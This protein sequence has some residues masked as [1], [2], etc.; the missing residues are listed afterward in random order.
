MCRHCHLQSSIL[1]SQPWNKTS[2]R[3][4]LNHNSSSCTYLCNSAFQLCLFQVPCTLVLGVLQLKFAAFTLFPFYLRLHLLQQRL[5][6]QQYPS[7]LSAL[8]KAKQKEQCEPLNRLS[9]ETIS[10]S[11]CVVCAWLV[12]YLHVCHFSQKHFLFLH[13][14]VF[15]L[16]VTFPEL[17]KPL[18]KS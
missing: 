18:S 3:S 10:D 8:Q 16:T 11:A 14:S 2:H 17:L 5:Q 9:S 12:H 15:F 7:V 1:S 13:P 4:S 6:I